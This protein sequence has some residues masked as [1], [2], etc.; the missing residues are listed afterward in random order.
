MSFVKNELGAY[1]NLAKCIYSTKSYKKLIPIFM[2][3]VDKKLKDGTGRLEYVAL[4][5]IE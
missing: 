2:D 5:I 4:I 1:N 3:G